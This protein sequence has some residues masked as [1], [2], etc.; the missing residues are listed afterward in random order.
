[1]ISRLQ[2][3][4]GRGPP[5]GYCLEPTKI[6]LVVTTRNLTRTKAFFH[7]MVMKVVIGSHYPGG[8]IGD[9]DAEST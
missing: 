4:H 6:I 5:Q 3:L 7:G 2:D 8:F 1:M 9:W